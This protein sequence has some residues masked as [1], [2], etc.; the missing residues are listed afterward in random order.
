LWRVLSGRNRQHGVGKIGSIPTG[1]GDLRVE[2]VS[3][4][5]V[6]VQLYDTDDT[7]TFR[8]NGQA[9][10]SYCSSNE[11]ADP[12]KNCGGLGGPKPETFTYGGL[13]YSYSGYDGDQE[14]GKGIEY[15]EID[16]VTN[17]NLM[18]YFYG[19]EAGNATVTYSYTQP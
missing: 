14:G 8:G 1:K 11:K 15:I 10:V 12:T 5:D 3:D 6:D 2:L 17:R 19:Y 16:G 18:M 7:S 9:I 4:V 13:P